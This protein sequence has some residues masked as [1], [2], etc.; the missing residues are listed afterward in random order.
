[1]HGIRTNQRVFAYCHD[2]VG[3]GHLRR[4]LN[5]CDRIGA[6][7]PD[8]SFLL[9]TGTP[10][11]SCF[12]ASAHVDC[13]KLPALTKED[14]GTYRSKF[15]ALPLERLMRCRESLLRDAAEHFD[16]GVLLIDKAPLGVCCE[17]VPTLRWLRRHRPDVRVVFGMRDIEDDPQ[18]TI[19]QWAHD[20]VPQMLEDC[21][22]EVW[23]YGMR[24]VFDVAEQYRLSRGIQDKLR[25]MGY[26]SRGTCAHAPAQLGGA[27][28]VLVTVGGGTDGERVLEAYLAEAAAQVARLGAHSTVIGGPDLP[29]V[30]AAR[31]GALAARMPGVTWRDFEPCMTCRI[32]Q[33]DFIVS[34]GGYNTLCELAAAGKPALV[35]P[36]TKPRLEQTIRA[37]LWEQLGVVRTLP[38]AE[39]TPGALAQRVVELLERGPSLTNSRLDLRG[40]ERIAER[41]AEFWDGSPADTGAE[42]QHATAV[43][44]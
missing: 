39:L 20:R 1:M 36:R 40:L 28:E 13:I 22:D 43:C 37:R 2:S 14:N 31:L 10:Y 16:P 30:A 35:I 26:V 44:M 15:L 33:A 19:A 6:L 8:A 17:L 5:I 12:S 25:F 27:P 32:R 4:T 21:F 29:P 24:E 18:A 23:V 34:M 11:V 41:F 7:H 9:A 42:G 38:Q 3:I